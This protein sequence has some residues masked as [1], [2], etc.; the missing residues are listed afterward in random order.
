MSVHVG[1]MLCLIPLSKG[2][3]ATVSPE[4]FERL[5]KHRWY[6]TLSGPK[7]TPYP[8][9]I[10]WDR[11]A[12]KSVRMHREIVE[13]PE[14]LPVD[15]LNGDTLDNRRENLRAATVSQNTANSRSRRVAG[16]GERN[17]ETLPSG[18]YRVVICVAKRRFRFGTYE[19][20]AEA[21]AARDGFVA[22]CVVLGHEHIR[23]ARAAGLNAK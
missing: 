19:T 20:L 8:Y 12:K 17:V 15:H 13:A 5:S 23:S 16:S 10:R 22:A 7:A 21:K 4:D 6:T 1:P 11:H 3:A 2:M 18:H 9:A 14:T